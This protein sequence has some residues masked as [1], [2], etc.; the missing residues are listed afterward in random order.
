M[1]LFR[2]VLH[3]SDLQNPAKPFDQAVKWGAKI[4]QEFYNQVENEKR[5]GLSVT[6]FM[7]GLEDVMTVYKQEMGFNKFCVRPLWIAL[8]DWF[9]GHTQEQV[10]H[11]QSNYDN[12]DEAVKAI[13]E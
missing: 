6:P 12:Y 13:S 2:I 4:S 11:L 10:D 5:L 8:N 3:C 9:G 7:V 1:Q